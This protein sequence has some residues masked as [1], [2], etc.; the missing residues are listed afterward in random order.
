MNA[1]DALEF[2]PWVKWAGLACLIAIVG[3]VGYSLV[4]DPWRGPSNAE[5]IETV[6]KME[7]L[8]R[9]ALVEAAV[10]WKCRPVA[11]TSPGGVTAAFNLCNLDY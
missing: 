6:E 5:I 7:L 1:L 11:L 8:N 4:R 10:Q 9:V 3:G 2:R